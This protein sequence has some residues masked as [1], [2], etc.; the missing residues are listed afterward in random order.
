MVA[1]LETPRTRTKQAKPIR[2]LP[3]ENGV[4]LTRTEFECRYAAILNLRKA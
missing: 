4:S 1:V 3:L 2:P